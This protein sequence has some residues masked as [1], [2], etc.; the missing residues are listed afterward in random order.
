MDMNRFLTGTIILTIISGCS[1]KIEEEPKVVEKSRPTSYIIKPL[2]THQIEVKQED[3]IKIAKKSCLDDNAQGCI[4]FGWIMIK[5]G[6]YNLAKAAFGRA[7]SLGNKGSGMR[8]V[9]L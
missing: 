7:V 6:D 1:S 9:F 4:D 3:P 8:G 2:L 5:K